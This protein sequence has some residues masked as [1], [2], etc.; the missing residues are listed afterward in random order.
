MG[1]IAKDNYVFCIYLIDNFQFVV[2]YSVN[3]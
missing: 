1:A 2:R 3:F